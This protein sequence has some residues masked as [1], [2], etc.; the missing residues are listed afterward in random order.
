MRTSVKLG[1]RKSKRTSGM[2][3]LQ[4]IVTRRRVTRAIL[5]PYELFPNEWDD[6]GKEITINEN[7]SA[8][9]KKELAVMKINLHKDLQLIDKMQEMLQIKGD[10]SIQELVTNFRDRQQG[11]MFCEYISRKV[12]NLRRFNRF[13]TAH[14]YRYAAV[15]LLKYLNGKDIRIDQVN[16]VLIKAFEHY[17]LEKFN[18][19]NTVS[20]YMRSLRAAYNQAVVEKIFDAKKSEANPFNGVFTGNAKTQKR[21]ISV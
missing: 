17:L 10:Y 14:T 21:A 1:L 5:T 9:R 7:I 16:S 18:S 11:Q 6:T 3:K 12:E 4:I 20:C 13:G 8:K 19:K 2:C 15:S